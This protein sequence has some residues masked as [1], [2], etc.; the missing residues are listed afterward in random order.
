MPRRLAKR[1][2]RKRMRIR[3]AIVCFVGGNYVRQQFRL[4]YLGSGHS[5]A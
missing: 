5:W 4:E 3:D 2:K 1:G